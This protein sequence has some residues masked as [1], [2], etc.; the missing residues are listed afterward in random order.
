MSNS[1]D[2]K[3]RRSMAGKFFDPESKNSAFASGNLAVDSR[4]FFRAAQKA[5]AD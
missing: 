5:L 4:A 3:S 2:Q 1:I